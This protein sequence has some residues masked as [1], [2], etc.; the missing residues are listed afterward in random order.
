M[1]FV[2]TCGNRFLELMLILT[3]EA[4]ILLSHMIHGLSV[5]EGSGQES[6]PGNLPVM[7]VLPGWSLPQLGMTTEVHSDL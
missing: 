2:V 7:I 5:L 4:L 1:L 3:W 6:S